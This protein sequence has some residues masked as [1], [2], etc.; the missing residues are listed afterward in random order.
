MR[1]RFTLSTLRTLRSI[2]YP[3]LR[4]FYRARI[5]LSLYIY[6]RILECICI[7]HLHKSHTSPLWLPSLYKRTSSS[8][9]RRTQLR[10]QKLHYCWWKMIYARETQR[11]QE[12]H[13]PEFLLESSIIFI[14]VS[15]TEFLSSG[16]CSRE[17]RSILRRKRL[18]VRLHLLRRL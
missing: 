3:F 17:L 13:R 2:V 12:T 11:S 6:I 14:G 9:N 5:S 18:F 15:T 8:W 16:R 1:L 7:S 10:H 4:P